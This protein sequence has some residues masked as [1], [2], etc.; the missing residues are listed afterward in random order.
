MHKS[1]RIILK[2]QSVLKTVVHDGW[3][4]QKILMV[5]VV[6][7]YTIN[8]FGERKIRC[9]AD[10]PKIYNYFSAWKMLQLGKNTKL[11]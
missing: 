6:L 8:W 7:V 3:F 10:L 4:K 5:I 2:F 1:K 9:C 11:F